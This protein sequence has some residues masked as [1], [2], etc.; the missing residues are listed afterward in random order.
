[1]RKLFVRVLM[2]LVVLALAI[3]AFAQT[4]LTDMATETTTVFNGFPAE[5]LLGIAATVVVMLAG[6]LFRMVIRA[7]R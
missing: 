2:S 6:Y 3:P 4:T 1:M 5:A 7:G